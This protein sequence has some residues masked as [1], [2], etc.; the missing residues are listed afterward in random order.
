MLGAFPGLP[1]K[2]GI[3]ETNLE[4]LICS[5]KAMKVGWVKTSCNPLTLSKS[6]TGFQS[7]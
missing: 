2:T 4:F 1:C 7:G 5:T 6:K 3:Q